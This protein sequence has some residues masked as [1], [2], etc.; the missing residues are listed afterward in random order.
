MRRILCLLLA[1]AVLLGT[2]ACTAKT[3]EES[4]TPV[5]AETTAVPEETT[6]PDEE[7]EKFS[8][9]EWDGLT[10]TNTFAG[11]KATLPD[12]GWSI[13]DDDALADMANLEDKSLL[14]KAAFKLINFYDMQATED[15]SGANVIVMI[16][17]LKLAREGEVTAEDYAGQMAD[18]LKKVTDYNYEVGTPHEEEFCGETYVCLPA[19]VPEYQMNQE[20]LMRRK[21]KYMIELILTGTP[22]EIQI[23]KSLF[24]G[25]NESPAPVQTQTA[26]PQGED[27][28]PTRCVWN[29]LNCTN[30]FAQLS[31]TLPSSEWKISTEVKLASYYNLTAAD[32]TT[33]KV[34]E[35]PGFVDFEIRDPET[36]AVFKLEVLNLRVQGVETTPEQFLEDLRDEW[37]N[38]GEFGWTDKGI[39]KETLCGQEYTSLL[40]VENEDNIPMQTLVRRQGDCLLVLTFFAV[41]NGA[42]G[43]ASECCPRFRP[44][45]GWCTPARRGFLS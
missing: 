12:T 30:D 43:S 44:E 38:D 37:M 7:D 18:G 17:N 35:L 10:Y 9:G 21:G 24:Y 3:P 45:A 13:T 19:E 2:T 11:F 31:F 34:A 29:G 6:Q 42:P 4:L 20:Y 8:R 39:T 1:A 16:Q 26:L 36:N 14:E 23:L 41:D 28:E 22:E 15:Q 25:L 27:G 32:I 5:S 33:D 40:L